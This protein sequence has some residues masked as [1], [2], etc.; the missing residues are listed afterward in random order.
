MWYSTVGC[1]VMLILSQRAAPYAAEAQQ[2]GKVH[3]LG[4]LRLG[5]A[6]SE[7]ECLAGRADHEV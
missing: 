6:P 7:A 1:I 3:R 5:P 4:Y 2:R